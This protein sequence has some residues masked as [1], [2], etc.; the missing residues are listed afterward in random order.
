MGKGANFYHFLPRASR[1]T[2]D[3]YCITDPQGC[4]LTGSMCTGQTIHFF[5]TTCKLKCCQCCNFCARALPK[6]KAKSRVSRLSYSKR[7][8][9]K[10]CEWCFLC[11]SI[12]LW[13]TCTKCPKC[14]LKSACRGKT[15]KILG[16]LA[17]A[18]CQSESNS[19]FET[20]LHPPL[21]DLAK[22][23]KISH[24]RKLL[25]QSSQLQL[26][27][28]GITSAYRQKH[29]RTGPKSNLSGFL[30][31]TILSS[32]TQQIETHL[33]LEQVKSFPQDGK[34]QNG[35]TR[36]HQDIPPARGVG[37]FDRLQGRL[38]PYTH[39]GTGQKYLRFHVQGQ[40]SQFKALPLVCHCSS[41]GGET[42]GH[43]QGYK[44]PP[45][46]RRLVGES[47]IPPGL[48][49]TDTGP[50]KD[51]SRTK[52][53][54]KFREINWNPSRFST[55]LITS[56]TSSPAW[57]VQ[58]QTSGKAFKTKYSQLLSLPACPGFLVLDTFVNSHREASSHRSSPHEA[59][60]VTFEKQL[61]GTRITRKGDS[62]SQVL[63]PT[64]TMVVR[65]REHSHR[66]TI[67]WWL[68][69]ENI[70]TGQPLHPI[71]HALQIFTNTSKEGWGAQLNECTAR[72]TW[73][74][75]EIKLH[76]NYLELKQS[77]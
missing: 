52:V 45:V 41:E 37:Y 42:D 7:S 49:P 71:K 43:T 17:G 15:S 23:H 72:G 69:G 3:S 62:N 13:S 20:G 54:C 21:L 65:R 30:Q 70:L 47:Q 38:L 5:Q 57:F 46:P 14:C 36:N 12:V 40:T 61:E 68:D 59:N 35:D 26:P 31:P 66:P 10:V 2:N 9:I 28:R 22:S 63:A 64:S 50:S 55:S 6:E 33:R 60:S 39:T 32:K 4:L 19:N 56:S 77:F 18:G 29:R 67:Q 34:I 76:I 74:L 44:N 48:S 51:M 53:A 1:R 27:V 75:P 16:N 25:C 11:H 8:Q 24:S 58:H 73:S